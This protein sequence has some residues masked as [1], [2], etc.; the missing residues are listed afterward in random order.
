[1]R[2]EAFEITS[3]AVGSNAVRNAYGR[4]IQSNIPF[5]NKSV[6]WIYIGGG[7]VT[8]KSCFKAAGCRS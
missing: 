2:N 6:W 4:F 8:G 7:N 1:M 3:S 5:G